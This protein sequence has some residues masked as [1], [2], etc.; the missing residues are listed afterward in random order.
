MV[1]IDIFGHVFGDTGTAVGF[2][3]GQWWLLGIFLL[4]V[5]AIVMY[6]SGANGR[7]ITLMFLI[8]LIAMVSEEIF[9]L[10]SSANI[11]Q[12]IIFFLLMFAGWYY[13]RWTQ[14]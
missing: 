11:Y 8:G 2:F 4:T 12:T 1:A 13:Y 5:F 6:S 3:G 14:T 10:V 7:A 9:T